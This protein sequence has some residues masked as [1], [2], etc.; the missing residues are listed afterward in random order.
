MFVLFALIAA[1][2]AAGRIKYNTAG[3]PVDSK[4]NIHIVPHT[5]DGTTCELLHLVPV[6]FQVRPNLLFFSPP[7]LLR[8]R[9]VRFVH[10]RWY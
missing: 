9:D 5:H 10:D 4:L 2:A 6:F 7:F 1:Q 3:G 8:G